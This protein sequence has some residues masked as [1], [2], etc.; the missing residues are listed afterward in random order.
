MLVVTGGAGFI[1]SATIAKLNQLG[2]RDIVGVDRLADDSRRQNLA[3]KHMADYLDRDELFDWLDAPQREVRGVIHLGACTDTTE[4]DV[5]FLMRNNYAY[6]KGLWQWCAQRRVPFIYASSAATYGRG[7]HGYDDDEETTPKLVPRNPYGYSKHLFD[8]W[9]LTQKECPPVWAGLK[10]F[11]VYGPNE[12]HKGQMASVVLSAFN[13]IIETGR[14]KLFRSECKGIPDGEQQRDFI[15]VKD[16]VGV[17]LFVLELNRP[18]GLLNVGTGSA[19]TFR[20]LVTCVFDALGA[21]VAIDYVP[22]PDGLREGYQYRTVAQI[23]K[24]R[25][26]GW[27]RPFVPIEGGVREYVEQYLT[28]G[29]RCL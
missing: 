15:Y 18:V 25:S 16:A 1:G 11:N 7:E 23:N 13:Q 17:I 27:T 22:M 9:A 2:I 14:V 24:L 29:P 6:T 3:G 20:D 19:R 4:R 26:L 5:D 21:P 10:F 12:Y 28:G 8:L